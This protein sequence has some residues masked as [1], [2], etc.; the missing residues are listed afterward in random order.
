MQIKICG[1]TTENEIEWLNENH[2]DYAG[3][4]FFEKSKRNIS[5]A[6]A[7]AI[8]PRLNRNI[9]KV[10]VTVSPDVKLV[11]TLQDTG[12]DILQVHKELSREVLEAA[13]VPVW[14]AF[15][16]A[17]PEELARKQCFFGELPE[18]LS[19]KIQA[20]VVD[21]ANFG[22]GVTFDWKQRIDKEAL[23]T[24][25]GKRKFILAGGLRSSNVQEGMDIFHPDVV[26][27]SSGVEGESGKKEKELIEEFVRKVR[28]H[29]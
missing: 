3:F 2:V 15:N 17:D 19:K 11:E 28:E 5:P 25:F 1:I 29:E 16:V 9:R 7:E 14:Y 23:D 24:I 13:K 10:G 20:I 18:N 4:V 21:G 6:E 12:I 26:D 27:V 8:F 22:S